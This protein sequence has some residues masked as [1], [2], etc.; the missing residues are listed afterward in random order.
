MVQVLRAFALFRPGTG[1]CQGMNEVVQLLLRV[2]RNEED[3]FWWVRWSSVRGVRS[4]SDRVERGDVNVVPEQD[5]CG[6]CG[7]HCSRLLQLLCVR[8]PGTSRTPE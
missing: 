5:A 8:E 4:C 3:A 6:A 1:Y 2:L 7:Q